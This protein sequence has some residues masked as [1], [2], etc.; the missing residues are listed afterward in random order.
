M[1]THLLWSNIKDFKNN[2]QINYHLS[3]PKIKI[4]RF[5]RNYNKTKL[6]KKVQQ[7]Q[8][9]LSDTINTKF[10]LANSFSQFKTKIFKTINRKTNN[11]SM[12][13]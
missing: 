10:K 3:Y 4:T 12:K 11:N 6:T 7:K 5:N 13:T 2:L 9:K 8:D 1:A